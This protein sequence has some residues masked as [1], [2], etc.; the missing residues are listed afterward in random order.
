MVDIW[1]PI[2]SVIMTSF[3]RLFDVL[4]ENLTSLR[5][6]DK[7]FIKM[8][9]AMYRKPFLNNRTYF[10]TIL[11]KSIFS[12]FRRIWRQILSDIYKK[13]LRHHEI[14]LIAS[15]LFY[16]WKE[17][18]DFFQILREMPILNRLTYEIFILDPIWRHHW[19]DVIN[20]KFLKI[21]ETS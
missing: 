21:S 9:S 19:S 3:F 16:L 11:K 20:V 5:H 2:F 18:P 8:S 4:S 14:Y 12:F 13:E 1:Y 7:K 6:S 10:G 17:I 15:F